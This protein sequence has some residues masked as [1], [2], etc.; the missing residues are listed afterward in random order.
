[1]RLCLFVC[2][3]RGNIASLNFNKRK[4]FF[5][6]FLVFRG[7][8]HCI[9]E[10]E[11]D[12]LYRFEQEYFFPSAAA[13]LGLPREDLGTRGWGTYVHKALPV[14]KILKQ[15]YERPEQNNVKTIILIY[16]YLHYCHNHHLCHASS[17][18]SS[19]LSSPPQQIVI[20]RKQT[21]ET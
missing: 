2:F 12:F 4:L 11:Q 3:I 19:S 6:L 7:E 18:L 17:L 9:H 1:M 21:Q 5:Y 13:S 14:N 8:T 10:F 20:V 15:I 16:Y